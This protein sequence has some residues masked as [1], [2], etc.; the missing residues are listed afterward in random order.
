MIL[1]VVFALMTA[2]AVFAVLWP[3]GRGARVQ[4]TGGDVAVYKD[5]LAEIERDRAADRIA[6]PEAEAARVEVSRRLLAAADAERAQK[7]LVAL[8][9]RRRAAAVTTLVAMPVGALGLYLTLGSPGLP[10]EPLAARHQERPEQRSLA[11]LVTQVEAHL[12]R[13]PEDGRGW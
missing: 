5:Q 13:N 10:G 11:S 9:W 6:A 3:L 12:A 8:P 4:P 7:G 1:W 2:A